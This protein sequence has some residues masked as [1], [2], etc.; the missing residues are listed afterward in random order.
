MKVEIPDAVVEE[1]VERVVVR[2]LAELPQVEPASPYMTTEQ[3]AAYLACSRQ[4]V[5]DLLS[6][7]KLSRHKEGARTLVL[8]AE[9]EALVSRERQSG[10]T[11]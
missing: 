6:S 10:R 11:L 1:L 2:V 5:H 8:R 7:G 3:A 4:R 9:L